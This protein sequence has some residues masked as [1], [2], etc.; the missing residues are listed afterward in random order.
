M[1][2]L[3]TTIKFSLGKCKTKAAYSARLRQKGI[4]DLEK[5]K[6]KFEVLLETPLL[7][8]IKVDGIE[9]VVHG[10]GELLFK[11]CN[12]LK[13][14]EKIAQEIYQAGIEN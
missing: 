1:S 4:L 9:V 11:R 13:L 12:D 8:V 10:H 2:K 7:L 14:M 3:T 5:I 6:G